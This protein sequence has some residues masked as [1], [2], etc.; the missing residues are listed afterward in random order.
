[1]GLNRVTMPAHRNWHPEVLHAKNKLRFLSAYLAAHH[2][3]CR[4][5]TT[6]PADLW[7]KYL[8]IGLIPHL[9]FWVA[10]TVVLG[11]LCGALPS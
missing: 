2:G 1:M 9:V 10:Y 11:S 5:G 7:G 4:Q 8:L 6:G 3:P